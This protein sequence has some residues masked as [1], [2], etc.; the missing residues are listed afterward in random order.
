MPRNIIKRLLNFEKRHGKTLIGLSIG[1]LVSLFILLLQNMGGMIDN[2]E[3]LLLNTRN[4]VRYAR[5]KD[6]RVGKLEYREK[7]LGKA[8]EISIIKLDGTAFE[9]FGIFPFERSVYA[10]A[11]NAFRPGQAQIVLDWSVKES[12]GA[13]RFYRIYVA[14]QAIQ[15]AT[16][17]NKAR[18]ITTVQSAFEQVFFEYAVARTADYYFAVTTVDEKGV[19]NR[20]IVPN[21]NATI[22]PMRVIIKPAFEKE[23]QAIVAT[24]MARIKKEQPRKLPRLRDP[25]VKADQM[26]FTHITARHNYP[27]AIFYD[28]FFLRYRD[29]ENDQIFFNALKQTS[30]IF[31]DYFTRF[32]IQD[33][34]QDF[35]QR[36]QALQPF[37]IPTDKDLSKSRRVMYPTQID[38]PIVPVLNNIQG[39]GLAT[40]KADRDD[41]VRSM[42]M[43]QQFKNDIIPGRFYPSAPL[44]LALHH[45]N[46]PLSRI[47]IELGS[48]ILIPNAWIRVRK[49]NGTL[50][51][52]DK[53][54]IRIPIDEDGVM[55]INYV[56]E[57]G[58]FLDSRG[59][60]ASFANFHKKAQNP[61]TLAN[62]IYLV[63][64]HEL[65]VRT[66]ERTTDYWLTP[67]GQ[68]YGIEVMA[69]ALN[70]IITRQFMYHLPSATNVVT[71]LF[72]SL[73]LGLVM[74]RI[75]ILRGAL[76]GLLAL[77][78]VSFGAYI[79]YEQNH[80]INM[81]LPLFAI[82]LTF[83][84]SAVYKTSVEES[85]KRLITSQFSKF[86]S[87]DVVRE[88]IKDPDR[89]RLG[90]ER[91]EVTVL[92]SDIR[93]FTTL[94]EQ[95]EPEELV[96]FL[97]EYLG[98]M[99]ARVIANR[100]T[101]DKYVGDEIM[102][103]WGAPL[104]EPDHA[105]LACCTALEMMEELRRLNRSWPPER[106]L[107]IGIGINTGI[108]LVG[109]MGS[110]SRMDYTIMG[111]MVNLGAR[112]EGINKMYGTN[113]IISE[114]TYEAVR[115]RVVV[116]EL[117]KVR[118]KGKLEP[119][120]IY[121][122]L[123]IREKA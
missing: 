110:E 59:P 53:Q 56:G 78:L 5:N 58:T 24:T 72:F 116:R 101:L 68:M 99:T 32:G 109:N 123:D 89:V 74:P 49:P 9:K 30:K 51:R 39:I 119:T 120:T 43:I 45:F 62:K 81:T 15:T 7:R 12:Q 94:S 113:V 91:R 54:D 37:S 61:S 52:V 31:V 66:R 48:H 63:G 69:N 26:P 28:I 93:S 10:R 41:T 105:F 118:A 42:R 3:L 95:M 96:A 104:D 112:L 46:V 92:F 47:R 11:L 18:L 8:D 70:T 33:P 27:E 102:A 114:F 35:K 100:G 60:S 25:V 44:V 106:R 86:V 122:L 19:E 21:R 34:Y 29:P 73:L 14:E 67:M 4:S 1:L 108:T 90:G 20:A 82:F 65:G 80:I 115:D 111:D 22:Y 75:S 2:L 97:N 76:V 98:A 88:L 36:L 16:D 17:L 55:H 50:I 77:L 38:L 117:D 84:F 64:L 6:R 40:P 103:F 83:L 85:Q 71:V 79:L 87:S 57:E 107:N 13:A 121:E 23:A